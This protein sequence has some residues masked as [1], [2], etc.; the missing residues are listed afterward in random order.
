M[1][2]TRPA[3]TPLRAIAAEVAAIETNMPAKARRRDNV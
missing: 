1:N 3:K 2:E